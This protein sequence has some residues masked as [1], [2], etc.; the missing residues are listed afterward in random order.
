LE[1]IL[2]QSGNRVTG[3]FN[4]NSNHDWIFKDGIV[5]DNN[6]LRFTV[7]R[8]P[9]ALAQM[10]KRPESPDQAVGIGELVMDRGSKSFKGTVLGAATSGTLVGRSR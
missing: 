3:Q 2:Q 10:G 1:L 5:D 6:T 9:L 4:V 8:S 7:V